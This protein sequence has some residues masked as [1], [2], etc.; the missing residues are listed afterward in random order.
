MLNEINKEDC[1]TGARYNI[2]RVVAAYPLNASFTTLS[3]NVQKALDE[4]KHPLA[5][6][7]HAPLL[8]SLTSNDSPH[9]IFSSLSVSLKRARG[10]VDDQGKVG[11]PVPK[12]GR[13]QVGS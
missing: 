6:L 3:T 5:L 9:T 2:L 7:K 8:A 12:R 11:E 1:F 13:K 4:D 10:E